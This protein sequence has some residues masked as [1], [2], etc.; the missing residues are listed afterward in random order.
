MMHARPPILTEQYV[1][2]FI[3]RDRDRVLE[4]FRPGAPSNHT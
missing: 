3:Y 4:R 1:E 2:S